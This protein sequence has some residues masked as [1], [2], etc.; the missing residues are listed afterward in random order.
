M[1]QWFKDMNTVVT[2][3]LTAAILALASFVF[4]VNTRIAVLESHAVSQ[5]ATA[6][7][8]RE[9]FLKLN[10]SIARLNTILT[11]LNDR[12]ARDGKSVSMLDSVTVE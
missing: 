1:N 6:N 9:N 2:G 11:V 5:D 8:N 12:L 4:E 3:L 10:E 7:E